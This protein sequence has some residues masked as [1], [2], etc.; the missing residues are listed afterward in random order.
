MT[1]KNRTRMK[2]SEIIRKS[3]PSNRKKTEPVLTDISTEKDVSDCMKWYSEF[4][5]ASQSKKWL[6]EYMQKM[7]Y[8]KEIIRKVKSLSWH[9]SGLEIENGNIINLKFAGFVSRMYNRGYEKIIPES[10]AIRMNLV[11]DYFIKTK[12]I[13]FTSNVDSPDND[14]KSIQDHIKTQ[15]N[16]L[17]GELEG[18]LDDFYDNGFKTSLNVYEWLKQ[19]NVKGLIAKKIGEEFR[20]LFEEISNIDIDE[21]LKEG[22]SNFKKSQRKKYLNF[23][24]TLIGDCDRYSSNQNKQRKPRAK[25]PVTATKLVSKLNYKSE[26]SEYKITSINPAE[27]IGA[28]SLWVFNVKY[29]KLGIYTSSNSDGLSIKGSTLQGFDEEKSVQKTLRKPKEILNLALKGP[30]VS[31]YKLFES[32]NSK[33]QPLTGRINS[34]TILLRIFK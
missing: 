21:D 9:K 16:T 34:E 10:Y 28:N 6:I 26:D 4:C 30:K 17:C 24:Q 20:P 19:K 2:N 13:S 15:V 18:E 14:N 25:K 33:E 27:I 11:I 5:D 23:L 22:Y 12:S 31:T 3:L 32:I 29:R 8:D 1:V 7:D